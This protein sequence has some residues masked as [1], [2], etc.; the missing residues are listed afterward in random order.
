M[1]ELEAE[2]DGEIRRAKEAFASARK[3]ERQFKELQTQSEDDKRMI[4]ELQ[5][6]LDK[7]QIKMKAYKRQLEEQEEVSQLT[8]SKYRKAQQQIEEAEHRADMAER[9]IT[10]KRTM[11]GPGSRAVSVVREINSMSRGNRATSIM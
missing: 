1:R 7:T 10:I 8:M 5:D 2:L 4:L 11:G 3:Y 6:L 9:T